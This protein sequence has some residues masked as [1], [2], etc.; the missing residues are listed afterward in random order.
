MVK[1]TSYRDD[2]DDNSD[3][4]EE[5]YVVEKV[6]DK[7]I[8]NG[9]TKYKLKWKDYP[10][11]KSTWESEKNLN[12]PELIK[13]YEDSIANKNNKPTESSIVST[14]SKKST[15]KRT[16]ST[17]SSNDEYHDFDDEDDEKETE[18][19]GT[20][21]KSKR[22]KHSVQTDDE[23]IQ[24]RRHSGRKSVKETNSKILQNF[25]SSEED[26]MAEEFQIRRSKKTSGSR[27]KAEK[28]VRNNDDDDDDGEDDSVLIVRIS[29]SQSSSVRPGDNDDNDEKRNDV[30]ND[31]FSSGKQKLEK[32]IR[33]RRQNQVDDIQFLVKLEN[34][35]K[36]R[37]IFSSILNKA[38]PQD[39]ISF[40]EKKVEFVMD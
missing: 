9:I 21:R 19:K 4:D 31:P 17:S 24:N 30:H 8:E 39:V 32:I 28:K 33:V 7:K 1:S 29:P 13:E 27:K 16:R 26:D 14:T 38:Y 34:I 10:L 40:W 11:S 22:T 23:S 5:E 15:K 35:T 12:C 2:D 3:S 18:S 25:V 36:P 20:S 37:W 6:L